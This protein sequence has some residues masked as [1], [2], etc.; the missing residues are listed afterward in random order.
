MVVQNIKRGKSKRYSTWRQR[1]KQRHLAMIRY[2]SKLQNYNFLRLAKKES[3]YSLNPKW[4]QRTSNEGFSSNFTLTSVANTHIIPKANNNAF[5]YYKKE[6]IG[7]S[8]WD[9]PYW[10]P[11]DEE[12]FPTKLSHPPIVMKAT[13]ATQTTS[14]AKNSPQ[15]TADGHRLKK[16][17]IKR[18]HTV[19]QT[20]FSALDVK[21]SS[22][23]TIVTLNSL[24]HLTSGNTLH[25]YQ[26]TEL[27]MQSQSIQCR[28]KH[29]HIGVQTQG[30]HHVNSSTQIWVD[31]INEEQS[32]STP[33][34][35]KHYNMQCSMQCKYQTCASSDNLLLSSKNSGA[36]EKEAVI[37]ML[38]EIGEL[39]LNQNHM[40]SNNTRLLDQLSEM[41][42]LSKRIEIARLWS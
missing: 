4:K 17:T 39:V 41:S 7:D 21:D 9:E 1:L 2:N 15:T 8:C 14:N 35:Y 26:Q 40:L 36:S 10:T 12:I 23:Q 5:P 28:C 31:D 6:Y 11:H 18:C 30:S 13:K 25:K 22:Q 3:M 16:N 29:F 19:T 37:Y 34:C 32:L 24:H 42:L 33:L 38:S 27:L 20:D